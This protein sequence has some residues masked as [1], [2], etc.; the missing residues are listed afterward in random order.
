MASSCGVSKSSACRE[1][2]EEALKE[3]LERRFDR[4]DLPVIYI[5]GMQFGEHHVI[6]GWA[7]IA[8]DTSTCRA[9]RERQKTRRRWRIYWSSLWRVGWTRRPRC[10]RNDALSIIV[11]DFPLVFHRA[12]AI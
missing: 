7:W 2:A 10:V 8:R 5:D 3:L 6:S 4:I 11:A 1:V 9:F 12:T